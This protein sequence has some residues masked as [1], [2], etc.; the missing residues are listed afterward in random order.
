M[1]VLSDVPDLFALLC[2]LGAGSAQD[3][4][5]AADTHVPASALGRRHSVRG[6]RRRD[7]GGRVR[8]AAADI[9]AETLLTLMPE[10]H[11]LSGCSRYRRDVVC[12]SL[13][14]GV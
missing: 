9:R 1:R 8:P 14:W 4:P 7:G 3:V 2:F 5:T 10:R 12:T 11:C 13:L 6:Q